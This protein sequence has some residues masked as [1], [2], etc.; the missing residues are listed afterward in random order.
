MD[1]RE[2]KWGL[3]RMASEKDFLV[4]LVDCATGDSRLVSYRGGQPTELARGQAASRVEWNVLEVR[5]CA[6]HAAGRCARLD[7]LRM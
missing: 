1:P 5:I 4:L 7:K 3:S 6:R 2:T